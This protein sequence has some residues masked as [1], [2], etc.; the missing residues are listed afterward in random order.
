MIFFFFLKSKYRVSVFYHYSPERLAVSTG[1]SVNTVRK[2]VG[3]LKAAGFIA[4]TNGNL[5]LSATHK[6]SGSKRL[7][8]VDTL[9]WTAWHQFEN[10]VYATIIKWNIKQQAFH[11]EMK[12][13]AGKFKSTNDVRIFKQYNKKYGKY[14][15]ESAT[16]HPINSV[17]QIARL[18]NRSQGWTQKML[19]RLEKMRYITRKQM[20][21]SLP[22]YVPP[23]YC[24]NGFAYYNKRRGTTSIHHGTLIF[25]NY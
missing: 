2:Y 24:E 8:S 7:I 16:L 5:W 3:R 11:C 14:T 4:K 21:E 25:V 18:F 9:P 12:S 17:R 13:L 10:R 23:K 6:K 19:C 15:K 1:L 20:I 22:G